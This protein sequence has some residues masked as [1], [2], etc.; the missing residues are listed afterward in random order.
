MRSGYSQE[1]SAYVVTGGENA[2]VILAKASRFQDKQ[3]E[4]RLGKWFENRL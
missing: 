4:S 3:P 1:S 2:S